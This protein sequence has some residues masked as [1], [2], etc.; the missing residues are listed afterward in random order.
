MDFGE[1]RVDLWVQGKSGQNIDTRCCNYAIQF[2]YS[3]R[4]PVNGACCQVLT[5][6]R[7]D[8]LVDATE[9]GR[10]VENQ[11]R[12]KLACNIDVPENRI[13]DQVGCRNQDMSARDWLNVDDPH[14]VGC[15][16]CDER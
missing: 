5:R 10:D 6:N 9:R 16:A 8:Y 4:T 13:D 12:N 15:Y 7:D 2:C 11:T 3:V 14:L 1:L